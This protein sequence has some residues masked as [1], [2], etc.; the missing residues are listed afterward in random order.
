MSIAL[1]IMIAY[2]HHTEFYSH[3]ILK[4]IIT[5]E[6]SKSKASHVVQYAYGFTKS[7]VN[8]LRN[9]APCSNLT[10]NFMKYYNIADITHTAV[11]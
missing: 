6:F 10:A 8:Q 1:G 9:F 2:I 11:F 7:E 4:F 3:D 5:I